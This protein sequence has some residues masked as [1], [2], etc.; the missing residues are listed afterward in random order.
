MITI[1]HYKWH[2]FVIFVLFVIHRASYVY[3]QCRFIPSAVWRLSNIFSS[4]FMCRKFTLNREN[5]LS[6]QYKHMCL[7]GQICTTLERLLTSLGVTRGDQHPEESL[8]LGISK[9]FSTLLCV[10]S[11]MKQVYGSECMGQFQWELSP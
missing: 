10:P 7:F 1:F 11:I 4:S 6:V 5:V 9:A 2:V 3:I 8:A